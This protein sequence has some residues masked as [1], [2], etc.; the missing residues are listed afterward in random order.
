VVN[1]VKGSGKVE[2]DESRN[3]AI[4]NGKCKVVMDAK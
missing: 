1:G 4:L 3:I 2:K